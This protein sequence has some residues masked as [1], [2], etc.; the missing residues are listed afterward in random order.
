MRDG[1]RL[2][3]VSRFGQTMG[4]VGSVSNAPEDLFAVGLSV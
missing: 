1:A 4:R 3:P 2:R